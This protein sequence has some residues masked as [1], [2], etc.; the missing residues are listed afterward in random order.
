MN[1]GRLILPRFSGSSSITTIRRRSP[2]TRFEESAVIAAPAE[3]IFDLIHD[4]SIRMDWD[5][6]LR[7]VR[8]L[9]VNGSVLPLE[10]AVGI[11][12]RIRCTAV[13]RSGGTS[14]ECEYV[15]FN[16]PR[17]ASIRMI[18][19]PWFFQSFVARVTTVELNPSACLMTGLYQFECRPR[20]LAPVF[21]N[22]VRAVFSRETRRR[23]AALK[24]YAEANFTPA[25]D[26]VA[27]SGQ[28]SGCYRQ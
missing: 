18:R 5:P 7:D 22:V 2:M 21:E 16:R 12:S 28:N 23:W 3:I 25:G 4:Y 13:W 14:L 15:S 20:W 17:T 11:G 27:T 1:A 26:R 6:F 10:T 24:Q 9:D 19:G 8:L